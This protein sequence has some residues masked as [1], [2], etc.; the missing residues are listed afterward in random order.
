M[1]KPKQTTNFNVGLDG[2]SRTWLGKTISATPPSIAMETEDGKFGGT[3]GTFDLPTGF[4][5]KFEVEMVLGEFNPEIWKH[6]NK[7]DLLFRIAAVR[8]YGTEADGVLYQ[9]R[10]LLKGNEAGTLEPGKKNDPKF[11]FTADYV[12]VTVA[13]KVIREIDIVN[14]KDVDANG[15]DQA[16]A[17]MRALGV[18]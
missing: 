2:D 18:G 5:E 16:A 12:K 3:I 8:G 17:T 7:P 1:A 10:G 13:G 14:P 6:F 11:T 9:M 4:Y 15:V